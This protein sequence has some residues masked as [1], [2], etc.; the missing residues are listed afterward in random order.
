[1]ITCYHNW[2]FS[3]WYVAVTYVALNTCHT[4]IALAT[5]ISHN[6]ITI[7]VLYKMA[8][9]ISATCVLSSFSYRCNL[10]PLRQ[11]LSLSFHLHMQLKTQCKHPSWTNHKVRHWKWQWERWANVSVTRLKTV[12]GYNSR[13]WYDATLLT[14]GDWVI[15]PRLQQ[16][17]TWP[18]CICRDN[19]SCTWAKITS[20]R[21]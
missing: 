6:T 20:T 21:L 8:I 9:L 13:R 18:L 3:C 11:N 12:F 4:N 7:N 14:A 2:D 10:I 19:T 16:H 17:L 1:M 5:I 15:Y